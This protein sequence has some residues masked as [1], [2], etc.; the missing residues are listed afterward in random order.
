MI[1]YFSKYKETLVIEG[2]GEEKAVLTRSSRSASS[3]FKG[4]FVYNALLESQTQ[5]ENGD[6]CQCKLN[7][8]KRDVKEKTFLV[9]SVRHADYS[10]Q[11]V[12]YECNGIATIYRP[13]EIY[14]DNDEV[15]SYDMEKIT[16][17]PVNHMTINDHLRLLQAGLLPS[18]TKE[19]RMQKCDIKE[20]DRIVVRDMNGEYDESVFVVDAIDRTKFDGLLAVQTSIDNRPLGEVI[21]NG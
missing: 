8:K 13:N 3:N 5:L 7:V 18:E 14:N 9:V 1:G 19:F 6:L 16:E 17:V 4:N 12:L 21:K 2:K 20:M 10:S 15:T 11:A